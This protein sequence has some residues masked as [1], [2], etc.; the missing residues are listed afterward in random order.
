MVCTF[1]SRDGG[2]TL[3]PYTYGRLPIADCRLRRDFFCPDERVK[4]FM[5][6][7]SGL[8]V[9][10]ISGEP[11]LSAPTNFASRANVTSSFSG[12]GAKGINRP[13]CAMRGFTGSAIIV[14]ETTAARGG[15]GLNLKKKKRQNGFG[16]FIGIGQGISPFFLFF[17]FRGQV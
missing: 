9:S 12:S 6:N 10:K 17:F 8:W 2:K 13:V 5:R 11:T 15:F 4:R 3:N 14:T 7:A 1:T 16:V